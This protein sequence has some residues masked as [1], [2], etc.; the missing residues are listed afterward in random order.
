MEARDVIIAPVISE[1]SFA[2][3]DAGK[4]T[5]VVRRGATKPQ[6]RRAVEQI[7][8]VHVTKVNTMQR[9]GKSVR[10]HLRWG[11]RPDRRLAVVSLAPGEKIEVFE[12]G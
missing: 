3:A 2:Q 9:R 5:F 7:W 8:G 4:Y 1:K 10:R 11:K 12:G 6:I